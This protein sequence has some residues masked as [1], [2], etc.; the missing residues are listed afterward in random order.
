MKHFA[1]AV[2]R[3]WSDMELAYAGLHQ[4]CAPLLGRLGT[5]PAPQRQALEVVLGL[6]ATLADS[7]STVSAPSSTTAARRATEPKFFALP[8]RRSDRAALPHERRLLQA[9]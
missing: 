2:A 5:L 4:L 3:V 6:S 8:L 9:R 7:D 1:D